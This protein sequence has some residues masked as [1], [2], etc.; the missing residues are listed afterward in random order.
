MSNRR[1]KPIPKNSLE[2]VQ[3]EITP[4]LLSG[5]QPNDTT[6]FSKTR[7]TDTSFKKDKTK[8]LHIGLEDIDNAILY[9]FKNIIKPSV[10]QDNKQIEVPVIY[11]APELWK[12][13][14]NDGYYRDFQGKM[15]VPIIMFKRD[16]IEKNR[17]LGN[18]LDGNKAHLFQIFE[19]RYNSKNAYDKFSVVTNRIPSQKIY[20]TIVPDYLTITYDCMI[21]TDFVEQNNKLIEAIE[22]ASDS[23]WGDINKWHFRTKIDSF[24]NTVMLDVGKDRAAKTSLKLTVNG[25]IIPNSIN[26]ELA[27]KDGIF[28]SKSQ[29]IFDLET[30]TADL[31][32]ITVAPSAKISSVGTSFT[33]DGGFG[34]AT[35]DNDVLIYLN[36]NK[37]VTNNTNYV[38]N[39]TVYFA[40]SFLTAPASLPAT[41]A[42]NFM[43][44]VNGQYVEATAITSFIDNG[45]GT[46]TLTIDSAQLGFTLALTDEVI[47]IGKFA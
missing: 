27:S 8:D 9:Y 19:E 21:F 35:I 45:N 28:Y 20:A 18:K 30:T 13:V 10:L 26:K 12:S 2:V 11:G 39:Y 3:N 46:C 23:Y 4:Y 6:V 40:A 32:V 41:S 34:K 33:A 44:F 15:M 36:T 7:G 47:A 16:S 5:K 38:N 24:A 42:S 43:F 22:F 1:L 14:Q 31:D 25:Y 29:V 17:T 37:T